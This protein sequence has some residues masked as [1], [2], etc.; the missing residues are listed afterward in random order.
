M[1]EN[2]FLLEDRLTKIKSIIEK[3]GEENFY[4]SFSGG[5]D[6]TVLSALLDMACPGNK[7]PR[8]YANTGIEYRLILEF[9]E[10]E[11]KREHPWEL[12]ILKPT[13]PIKPMLEK[14]GYPF[15]SKK[16]SQILATYQKYK[17]TENRPGI[18]HYLHISN[19][20]VNWSSQQSCPA[21][22][23]YQF[24][25]DYP[26]KISDKCCER[27]KEEPLKKWQKENNVKY[28]IIG[29]MASEGGRRHNA[30]C[31]AFT[32]GK[33]TAFQPLAPM[34]KEWEDWFIS[35]YNIDISDIYKE[36]Y[37]LPRTGCKGCPFAINLQKELDMLEE[38]FP[39][40]RKQCEIIWKPVYDEY[41]RLGYRL[42][43]EEKKE[44]EA[45]AEEVYQYSLDGFLN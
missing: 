32:N 8:V 33:F 43:K 13:V 5:K 1:T 2:E 42:K 7:I 34:T 4:L 3:Y 29:I 28:A 45:E 39:E 37:C 38:F 18:Q 41:R 19:D 22:L 16:H 9:V 15:K 6:S 21:I 44:A 31:L 26:L 20:G 10:R 36:P 30:Q 14:D 24:T 27:M 23:K 25:P 17:T 11:K 35:E 40:E 12:V